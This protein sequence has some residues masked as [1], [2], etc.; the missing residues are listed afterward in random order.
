MNK[1]VYALLAILIMSGVTIVLRYS[2]LIFCRGG[3]VPAWLDYLGKVLPFAM[4]PILVMYCIKDTEW[5]YTGSLVPMLAGIAATA[6]MHIW[7]KNTILSLVSG[8]VIYMVLL[9]LVNWP[10]AI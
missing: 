1:E 2:C 10:V 3:K 5:H 9:R 6:V 7:K 8:L 4:M